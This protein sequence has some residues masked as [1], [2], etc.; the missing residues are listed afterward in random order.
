MRKY[1]PKDSRQKKSYYTDR[2]WVAPRVP[3]EDV[4]EDGHFA[5]VVKT[6]KKYISESYVELGQKIYQ[7][8][9]CR[10]WTACATD[11]VKR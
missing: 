3:R 9:L 8:E 7:R 6:L 4:G 10:A 1:T 11:K 2:F 5:D